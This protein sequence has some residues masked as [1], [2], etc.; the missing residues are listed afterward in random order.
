MPLHPKLEGLIAR[1][2]ARTAAPQWEMPI[3][4]VRGAFRSLWTLA[5]T[6]M[7]VAV[8]AIEDR[9]LEAPGRRIPL[10]LYPFT[11][12]KE[13]APGRRSSTCTAGGT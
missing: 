7:P 6:G 5:I 8:A 1:K 9:S 4:E 13:P 3:E 12:R 11:D 2:L 10:R